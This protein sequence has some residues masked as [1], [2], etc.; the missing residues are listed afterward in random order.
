MGS[1]KRKRNKQKFKKGKEFRRNVTKLNTFLVSF[2]SGPNSVSSPNT[3][4][5]SAFANGSCSDAADDRQQ[6]TQTNVSDCNEL[7]ENI[8]SENPVTVTKSDSLESHE[9]N[10]SLSDDHYL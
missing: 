3:S 9:T 5:T 8:I 4:S 2:T 6:S 10:S 1:R 7:P